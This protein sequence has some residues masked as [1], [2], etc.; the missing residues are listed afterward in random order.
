[1]LPAT[2]PLIGLTTKVQL[3]PNTIERAKRAH[4]RSA[5]NCNL[6]L[7]FARR[8]LSRQLVGDAPEQ[9]NCHSFGGSPRV[10]TTDELVTELKGRWS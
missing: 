8:N 7:A 3:Q 2:G 10:R 4:N 5:V 9:R 6:L 1:M